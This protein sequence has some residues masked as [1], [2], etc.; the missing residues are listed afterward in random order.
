MQGV[1][2]LALLVLLLGCDPGAA[3]GVSTANVVPAGVQPAQTASPSGPAATATAPA[4]AVTATPPGVAANASPT[5]MPAPTPSPAPAP[6]PAPTSPPPAPQPNYPV[7]G[8]FAQ[9]WA[10]NGGLTRLGLPLSP[11]VT[12]PASGDLVVQYFE[13]ARFELHPEAPPQYFVELTLFG[14]ALLGNRPERTAPANPC[15][16][17]CARFAET[18]HTLRGTFLRYWTASGGLPVFGF[19]LTEE[20]R[21][22]N[23]ADGK[24]YTVQY[25][26]RA[27]FEYHPE[28]AGTEYEVLLGHLGREALAARPDVPGLARATVPDYPAAKPRPKVIVLDPGHERTTGGAQGIEYRDTLRTALAIKVRLEARGYVVRLTRPDDQTTL[29]DD[30]A[31]LPANPR[32]YDSGYLEGYVHASKILALQPDLAISIH[33]NAAPSGPGGGS[34][35]F[36]CDFGGP[37]NQ[38]LGNLVQAEIAAALRDRGYTPPYS[39]VSEDGGIGKPYGHLATLG[40]VNDTSGRALSNRMQ[41]LP[42]VLTEALFET[43]PTERAL[44]AD[45]A[46]LA[47]LADGYVRAIDAY[48]AAKP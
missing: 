40:N 24:E 15:A 4:P 12:D 7:E 21:E 3:S 44:I 42:I 32:A 38:Q 13:R 19:P 16:G 48:F 41:G 8:A 31:L 39:G 47:R 6:S 36:Y 20:I 22:V 11:A 29:L 10:Q 17:D 18:N 33:Y 28:N 34:T 14:A 26:E 27:R 35:T 25:F 46:T 1:L 37:Q 5:A 23:A 9:F 45:D 30:P 43:N 2:A